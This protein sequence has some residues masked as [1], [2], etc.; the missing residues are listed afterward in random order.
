MRRAHGLKRL[1][2]MARDGI[3]W[4]TTE[5]MHREAVRMEIDRLKR[6]ALDK[7]KALLEDARSA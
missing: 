7:A 4:R 3:S 6:E 5:Q 2:R 1:S